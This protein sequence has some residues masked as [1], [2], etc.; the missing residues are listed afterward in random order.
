MIAPSPNA[1]L[2]RRDRLALEVALLSRATS[3]LSSGRFADALNALN[4]HQREFPNGL[5]SE[6]RRAAKAQA[7][8]SLGRV[9]EGRSQ[10]SHLASHSPVASR[11]KQV[12]DA[13]SSPSTGSKQ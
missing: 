5:L 11:A 12:C 9:A 7:L 8:C 6:E 4:Q 10:L 13:A 2:P 3:A 1:V